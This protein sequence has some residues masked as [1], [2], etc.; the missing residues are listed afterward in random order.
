MPI[1][2]SRVNVTL[3]QFQEIS[4]GKYNA[5]EIRL[6]GQNSLG[7]VNNHV[8]RLGQNVV[9]LSHEEVMAVKTAFV[10][11]L[12]SGGV[13]GDQ[14]ARVRREL[15]LAPDPGA[16]AVDR[17]LGKRSMKPLTR[18]QAREILDRYAETINAHPGAL[19]I[20]TA[21]EWNARLS[22]EERNTRTASRDVVNNAL[23]ESRTVSANRDILL[24]ERLVAGD[25]D[26]LFQEDAAR[27]R[28][29]T[30][31]S[32]FYARLLH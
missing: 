25:F 26:G 23:D 7:K 11:A 12:A 6:T 27:M 4:S 3:Q 18:Q 21:A 28:T 1:D 13:G 5:G 16:E 2:F 22:E 30:F 32:A 8:S 15:G 19:R 17:N 14:I 20:R 29:S 10:K 31:F 24:F 9:P